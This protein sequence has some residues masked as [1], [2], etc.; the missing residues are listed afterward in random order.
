[1][2]RFEGENGYFSQEFVGKNLESR[3][4]SAGGRGGSGV[5]VSGRGLMLDPYGIESG[6]K[7]SGRKV[8]LETDGIGIQGLGVKISGSEVKIDVFSKRIDKVEGLDETEIYQE[9]VKGSGGDG[10]FLSAGSR[11]KVV[12]ENFYSERERRIRQDEREKVVNIMMN[13]RINT[14]GPDDYAI[15]EQELRSKLGILKIYNE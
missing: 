4:G 9:T 5:K 6:I 12:S 7:G 2:A 15:L 8:V 13:D 11:G 14:R 10:G 3:Y 1:L